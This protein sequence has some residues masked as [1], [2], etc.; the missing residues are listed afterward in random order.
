M[1]WGLGVGG[2]GRVG[3]CRGAG[4]KER[5][6]GDLAGRCVRGRRR[7][8]GAGGSKAHN[9]KGDEGAKQTGRQTML[10]A[11]FQIQSGPPRSRYILPPTS[12]IF[13]IAWL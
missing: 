7:F 4:L 5:N 12:D 11:W 6:Q 8:C 10:L 13:L 1:G 3:R 2:G 9:R